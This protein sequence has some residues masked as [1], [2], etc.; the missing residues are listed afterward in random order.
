MPK[1]TASITELKS[2]Y[3]AP[4]LAVYGGMKNLTAAGSMG[5]TETYCFSNDPRAT[6]MNKIVRC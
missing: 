6:N 1:K 2:A 4:L 3:R 5:V